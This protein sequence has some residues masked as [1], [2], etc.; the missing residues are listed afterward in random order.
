M[1]CPICQEKLIQKEKSFQCVHS[2]NFDIAKQGYVNL[3]MSASKVSGDSKE[4]VLARHHFLNHGYYDILKN[5]LEDLIQEYQPEVLVDLAC[6]EGYYTKGMAQHAKQCFGIDLSKNALKL[7]SREDKNSQYILASIFHVPMENESVD[8]ITNIF[9]PAPLEEVERLLK[10]DGIYLRVAP[11]VHHLYDFKRILYT[12]VYE[13]EIEILEHDSL[14]LIR[15]ERITDEILIENNQD[16]QDLF[17]MTPYY[18]KSNKDSAQK[19]EALEKCKTIID[20][21]IQIYRKES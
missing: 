6:G 1:I 8:V 7:A 18:W 13:N 9:A 21:D 17:M 3:L 5:K 19:L 12:E 2:H 16:I 11:H 20:F 14:K 15:Q 4:M 10:K